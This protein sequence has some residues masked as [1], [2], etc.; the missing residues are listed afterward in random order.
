MTKGGALVGFHD[1]R[2]ARDHNAMPS[3]LIARS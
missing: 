2:T 3:F 1:W